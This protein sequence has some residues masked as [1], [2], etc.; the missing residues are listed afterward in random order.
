MFH[1]VAL[2]QVN[3]AKERFYKIL[4]T[5]VQTQ[6]TQKE[7]DWRCYKDVIVWLQA[8]LPQP[9]NNTKKYTL[10]TKC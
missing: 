2:S 5:P 9:E 6:S 4:M 3:G 1:S 8:N 7:A 10:L